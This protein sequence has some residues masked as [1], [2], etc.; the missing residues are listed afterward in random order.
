MP[1]IVMVVMAVAIG[2]RLIGG[3]LRIV[4]V[5]MVMA[6]VVVMVMMGVRSG[7][8]RMYGRRV[9]GVYDLIVNTRNVVRNDVHWRNDAG[10]HD[11]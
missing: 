2:Q 4:R 8:I 7:G 1:M 3:V 11:T 5:M 9:G 6:T 10:K